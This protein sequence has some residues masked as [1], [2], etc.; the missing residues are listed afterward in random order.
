MN[1]YEA[2]STVRHARMLA[3]AISRDV[4]EKLARIEAYLMPDPC[5][6]DGYRDE[7]ICGNCKKCETERFRWEV[8]WG[9]A[10]PS[11]P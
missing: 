5:E 11:R 4:D 2:L 3:H 9:D 8:E 7:V 10:E 6:S 1:R